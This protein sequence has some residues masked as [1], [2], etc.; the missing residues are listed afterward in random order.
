MTEHLFT[1]L[2]LLLFLYFCSVIG[3]LGNIRKSYLVYCLILFIMSRSDSHFGCFIFFSATSLFLIFCSNSSLFRS[4]ANLLL[5]IR[6]VGRR[7][8]R[9]NLRLGRDRVE[10]HRR[11]PPHAGHQPVRRHQD[12]HRLPASCPRHQRSAEILPVLFFFLWAG[13]SA[14]PCVLQV[15]WSTP[16]A[17]SPSSPA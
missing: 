11:L 10:H 17:S 1:L 14:C 12:L 16:P 2:L 4:S 8:Q 3:S 9:R 13:F 5:L 6:T 15:G 7:E